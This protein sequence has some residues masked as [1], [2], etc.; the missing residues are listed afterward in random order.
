MPL[1]EVIYEN[2]IL[3]PLRPLD[4]AEGTRL[5]VTIIEITAPPL[6]EQAEVDEAAY[7][8]FLDRMDS[9]AA[10]PLQSL[11]QSHTARDHD[12]V[13]YPKQGRMP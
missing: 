3:R 13:L 9:I 6:S 2:G 4:L 12:A 8:A 1:V 10:L 11:P 7:Q 5:E